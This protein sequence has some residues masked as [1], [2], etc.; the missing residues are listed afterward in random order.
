[1]DTATPSARPLAPLTQPVR[2][3]V[4]GVR[5]WPVESQQRARRNALFASTALARR[6]AERLE[7]EEFLAA[8]ARVTVHAPVGDSSLPRARRG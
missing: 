7:V 8:H 5:R 2:R 3:L 4:D 6:R 1:M